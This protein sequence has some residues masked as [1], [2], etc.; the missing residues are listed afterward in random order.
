MI[1]GG[2]DCEL[3]Q[4]AEPEPEMECGDDGR[5]ANGAGGEPLTGTSTRTSKLWSMPLLRLPVRRV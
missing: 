5:A 2:V 3:G 1:K 4:L